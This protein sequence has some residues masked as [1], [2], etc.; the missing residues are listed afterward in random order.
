M[1]LL[2]YDPNVVRRH[3]R[4]NLRLQLPGTV[5]LAGFSFSIYDAGMKVVINCAAVAA[6]GALGAVARYLVA[7]I[8]AQAFGTGFPV[9]TFL[10]NI[11]GSFILGWFVAATAARTN[12]SDATRLAVAVGFVG[13]YT[14]FSTYMYESDAL[15]R[16]GAGIKA[17]INLAGSVIVGLI[18]VRLGAWAGAR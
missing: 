6:G 14:T 5:Q 11:T 3:A 18:A 8:C 13:A 4:P 17:T 7:V 16:N 12:V 10:I 15:L 9:G 1:E 2:F